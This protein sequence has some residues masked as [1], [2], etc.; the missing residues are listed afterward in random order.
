MG[1]STGAGTTITIWGRHLL[2]TTAVSFN[3]VP[4]ATFTNIGG[5]YVSAVVPAGASTGPVT[6]TNING[7]IKSHGSFTIR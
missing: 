3:G 7:T 1:A 5:D 4:A 2:G 6:L